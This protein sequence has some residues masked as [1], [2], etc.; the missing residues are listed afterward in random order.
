MAVWLVHA[1]LI[2]YLSVYAILQRIPSDLFDAISVISTVAASDVRLGGRGGGFHG[3][4]R[5]LC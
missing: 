2:L 1:V 4:A 3:G 5:S